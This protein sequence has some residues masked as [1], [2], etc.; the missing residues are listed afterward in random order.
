MLTINS[1]P[2][3]YNGFARNAGESAHPEL[4]QF[5]RGLWIPSLGVTGNVLFD[6][7]VFKSHG[8]LINM[9]IN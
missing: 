9:G 5:A 1:R 7:S 3:Y 4:W 2:S 8:T 6:Q